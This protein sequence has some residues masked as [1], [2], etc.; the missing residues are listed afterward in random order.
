MAKYT[1]GHPIHTPQGKIIYLP[2][3]AIKTLRKMRMLQKINRRTSI[4]PGIK[5]FL[6]SETCALTYP[7]V[8]K[9]SAQSSL[10][11]PGSI[12]SSGSQPSL[13][14]VLGKDL[15]GPNTTICKCWECLEKQNSL[16]R[17]DPLKKLNRKKKNSP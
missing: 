13:R 14:N 8:S 7:A 6:N 9:T 10:K 15:L 2:S 17:G 5:I 11:N 16:L 1:Q 12:R 3:W 4:N